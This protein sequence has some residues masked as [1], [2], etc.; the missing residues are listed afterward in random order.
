MK[1][2]TLIICLSLAVPVAFTSCATPQT[3]HN[4]EVK[5]VLVVATGVDAGMKVAAQL[6]KDGFITKLQWDQIAAVHGR[7]QSLL[8]LTVDAVKGNTSA[9]SPA[10]LAALAAEVIS[11]INSYRK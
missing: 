3:V 4:V 11:I 5:S 9:P 10:D 7:Y 6:F 8:K 1:K 2:L